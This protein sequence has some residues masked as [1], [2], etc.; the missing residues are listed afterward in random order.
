MAILEEVPGIEVAVQIDGKDVIEYDPNDEEERSLATGTQCPTVTK[1]IE[2]VNDAEFAIRMTASLGYKWGYKNHSLIFRVSIDGVAH[3]G[4]F[5]GKPVSPCR[6]QESIMADIHGFCS[7][8]QKWKV[9]KLKFS[10]VGTI[11]DCP[12]ERVAQDLAIAKNLGLIKVAVIR[13]T[14]GRSRPAR[15]KN[16]L[17]SNRQKFELAEKSVKG[18]AISHGTTFSPMGQ[19]KVP[20]HLE[21]SELPGDRGPIA[22]FRFLY[23]SRDSLQKN[24]IIPRSPSP[25]SAQSFAKLSPAEMKRLAKERFEQMRQQN[26]RLK[27]GIKPVIKRE[28]GTIQ[29]LTEDDESQRPAKRTVQFVDLTID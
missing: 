20:N 22:V 2:C 12:K 14:K 28:F 8:A 9:Y 17:D 29:D 13:C 5:L 3:H 26:N 1:Y 19:I 23:R 27:D 11:D 18:K 4:R 10:P 24:L 21:I 16:V 6:Q 7:Q 25:S 15:T